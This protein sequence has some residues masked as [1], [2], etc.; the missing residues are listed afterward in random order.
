MDIW[1]IRQKYLYN[2]HNNNYNYSYNS[3]NS[4]YNN[5]ANYCFNNSDKRDLFPFHF[6]DRL[7]IFPLFCL[8]AETFVPELDVKET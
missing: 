3:N 1:H 7:S 8:K 6:I 4:Y 5:S 2:N